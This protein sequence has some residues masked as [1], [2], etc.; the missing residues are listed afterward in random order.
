MLGTLHLRQGVPG[1]RWRFACQR[2]TRRRKSTAAIMSDNPHPRADELDSLTTLDLLGLI[3]RE[4]RNALDAVQGSLPE[5]GS[6]VDE[7]LL[8]L[9]AGG[10]LHYFGAGNSGRIAALD[11]AECPATF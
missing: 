4:D 2:A 3:H 6:A 10:T 9:R 1:R 7:I 5:I 11:A 8:R